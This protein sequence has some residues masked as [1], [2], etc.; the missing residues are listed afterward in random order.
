[1]SERASQPGGSEADQPSAPQEKR[2]AAAPGGSRVA[3]V[4]LPLAVV[5]GAG[6]L[7][8]T[9]TTPDDGGS[10]GAPSAQPIQDC[11][12]M[13]ETLQR[14]LAR[15]EL[16]ESRQLA[17]QVPAACHE[18]AEWQGAEAELLVLEG[19]VAAG[20]KLAQSA[21]Q[22]EPKLLSARR[23]E[24]L[25][26]L[27]A[28]EHQRAWECF[29]PL[30]KQAPDDPGTVFEA[31]RAAQ[32]ANKYRGAREGFLKALRLDPRHV[33]ARY[34]LVQ[35]THAIGANPEAKNHLKKLEQIARVDDPRLAQAR[36]LLAAAAPG[37]SAVARP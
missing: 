3:K 28:A 18:Q 23:V 12:S 26:L 13:L 34:R 15:Y 19:Q 29:A 2:P 14:A 25:A 27:E 8:Y 36:Q 33:E 17:A 30:L 7:V 5:V 1:M 4:L 35:L 22:R 32:Y 11:A 21:L 24:C 20:K 9:L 31:A 10:V 16:A 6:A 37:A